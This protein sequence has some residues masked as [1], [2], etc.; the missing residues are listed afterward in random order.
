MNLNT[1][2][3]PINKKQTNYI[4]VKIFKYLFNDVIN[5]PYANRRTCT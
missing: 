2:Q 4:K 1:E 3:A 5:K